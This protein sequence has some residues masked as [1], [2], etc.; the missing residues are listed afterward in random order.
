MDAYPKLQGFLQR[1]EQRPA[2][3]RATE[4][5]GALDLGAGAA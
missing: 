2:Y 3:Q 1:I 5:G 4:R